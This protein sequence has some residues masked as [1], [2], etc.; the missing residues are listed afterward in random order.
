MGGTLTWE[1][2][3]GDLSGQ[4]HRQD[5]ASFNRLSLKVLKASRL[6]VS[7]H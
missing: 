1:A 3:T 2:D 6:Q 7:K 4:G 5:T